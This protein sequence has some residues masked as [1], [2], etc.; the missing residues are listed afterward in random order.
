MKKSPFKITMFIIEILNFVL[1]LALIKYLGVLK[2]IHV[3]NAKNWLGL[4]FN[5]SYVVST[6]CGIFSI[7]ILY[8]AQ[9][10]YCKKMIKK[11]FRCNEIIGDLS[12]GIQKSFNLL[13]KAMMMENGLV[14]EPNY[15][16]N[17]TSGKCEQEKAQ[18]LIQ[19]RQAEAAQYWEFYK[20]HKVQ[21][22]ICNLSFTFDNNTLLIESIQTVFFININ[23]R[24]LDIVNNIKNRKPNLVEK[25]KRIEQLES[26][27]EH[28]KDESLKTECGKLVEDY[29]VDLKIMATYTQNLL[30]YLEYDPTFLKLFSKTFNEKYQVEVFFS[31]PYETRKKESKRIEKLVRKKMFKYKLKNFF[32]KE[33]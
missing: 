17:S 18:A 10:K 26:K 13:D 5:N 1:L 4:F 23:F 12:A 20:E 19:R 16:I 2:S 15:E 8:V 29:L 25:W 28:S 3:I 22:Y 27:Y 31:L 9:L 33:K 32:Y 24:L 7:I 30:E 6:L 14:Q 11:D 21:L